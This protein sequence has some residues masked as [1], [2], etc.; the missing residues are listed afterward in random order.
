MSSRDV[1]LAQVLEAI[2]NRL[3]AKARTSLPAQILAYNKDTGKCTVQVLPFDIE[4]DGD[5]NRETVKITP[6][7]DVPYAQL[8]SG[9]V[10]IKIPVRKGDRCWLSVS[11]SSIA[12]LKAGARGAHDPGTDRHH[13][14]ADAIA[15]P[16]TYLGE[17]EDDAMIEFTES[18]EIHAGGD[19]ALV[20]RAE[21]LSHGHATAAPGPVSPPV[22]HPTAPPGSDPAFPGTQIL[23]GG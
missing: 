9:T 8:G 18:G 13:H 15:E 16:W 2:G 19:S 21:F 12:R 5:G 4:V 3:L 17:D 7:P 11:S 20:T 1:T 10:R 23:K 14:L 22:L 6:L